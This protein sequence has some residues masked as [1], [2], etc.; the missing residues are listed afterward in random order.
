MDTNV[1]KI[2]KNKHF[3][4]SAPKPPPK[5]TAS[6]AKRPTPSK[7]ALNTAHH[8]SEAATAQ[9][10]AVVLPYPELI[11]S[12]ATLP[13]ARAPPPMEDEP[14]PPC[15]ISE[16]PEEI[17]LQIMSALAISDFQSFIKL[18]RVCKRLAYLV[19]TEESI[20]KRICIGPE[21]GYGGMVYEWKC[22]VDG[23]PLE[24]DISDE[25]A[26]LSLA[27]PP[28]TPTPSQHPPITSTTTPATEDAAAIAVPTL[29][30]PPLPT[31]TLNSKWTSYA[32]M[33]RHR[34]RI[35]FNGI[36][37]ST[38]N[39]VRPGAVAPS[40]TWGAAIHIVT[41]YRY[42]RFFRD[43]RC[44]S[45]L[46]THEP[47]EIVHMFTPDLLERVNV[48]VKGPGRQGRQRRDRTVISEAK[49]DPISNTYK[50]RWKLGGEPGTDSSQ[51]FDEGALSVE[52]EG[53]Y[54]KYTYRMDFHL[55]GQER[56][57]SRLLW[58]G[59]YAYNKEVDEWNE[60]SMKNEKGFVFSRVKAYGMGG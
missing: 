42:L 59:F 19:A 45:L 36:Y 54:E 29:L 27:T 53:V 31:I 43:G 12:F 40:R 47:S 60:I 33:F 23:T 55:K 56:G 22:K 18:A 25:L 50:G 44:L 46:T 20:W 26:A 57:R 14:L 9:P 39:Y 24:E 37:I 16:L 41:Y 3:P 7:D 51:E 17:L 4:P 2:Y 48:P 28:R 1:D 30:P 21:I 52:T 49:E 6:D 8:S 35:R 15:P 34:P 10:P 58:D 5:A 38:C 32:K 13:I 11:Q